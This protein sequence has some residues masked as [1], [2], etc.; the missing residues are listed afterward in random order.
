MFKRILFFLL[1]FAN[2][3]NHASDENSN[4]LSDAARSTS[5]MTNKKAHSKTDFEMLA[6]LRM[7]QN[8]SFFK[9]GPQN[10]FLMLISQ[11]SFDSAETLRKYL[12]GKNLQ[13]FQ[14]MQKYLFEGKEINVK[15]YSEI[16][17][18]FVEHH[19]L[20]EHPELIN[21]E[22]S[23]GH[24]KG[25]GT[26]IRGEIGRGISISQNYENAKNIGQA[27]F[28][29]YHEL[30]HLLLKDYYETESETKR[31]I[32]T[33]VHKQDRERRADIIG[34][35]ACQCWKCVFEKAEQY[36]IEAESCLTM[37][38]IVKMS[39]EEIDKIIISLR[40]QFAIKNDETHPYL[41]ER[42]LYLY[43]ISLNLKPSL[44][45][46]H[47]NNESKTESKQ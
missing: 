26:I 42:V 12:M 41:L 2:H 30:V 38:Q 11:I 37:E 6:R 14:F 33:K 43:L 7:C 15:N 18:R 24:S 10:Q 1:I 40:N 47:Q 44:C 3:F 20:F 8:D 34:A 25:G 27:R 23:S 9:K 29:A 31:C 28:A 32:K 36:L 21:V 16:Y 17:S 45:K 13:P 4:K 22:I 19:E 35:F 39:Q 5:T 46:Y